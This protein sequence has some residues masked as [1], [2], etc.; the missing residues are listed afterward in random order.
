MTDSKLWIG[1]VLD[2]SVGTDEPNWDFGI[3]P[4]FWPLKLHVEAKAHEPLATFAC[5]C[6]YAGTVLNDTST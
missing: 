1:G 2:L 5:V 3:I 6:F 4:E